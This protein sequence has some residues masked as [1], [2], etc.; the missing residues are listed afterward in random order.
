[1]QK[2]GFRKK[3]LFFN[4]NLAFLPILP[5]T[6]TTVHPWVAWEVEDY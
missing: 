6:P 5:I 1:M 2:L 4:G 3:Y